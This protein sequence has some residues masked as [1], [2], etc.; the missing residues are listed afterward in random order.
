MSKEKNVEF[1]D[2]T[3]K[4]VEFIKENQNPLFVSKSL[5]CASWRKINEGIS[6]PASI[7]VRLNKMS[8]QLTNII[9]HAKGIIR[10]AKS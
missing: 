1:F 7:H 3:V 5:P 9:M 8:E 2:L 6:S 10:N 4:D